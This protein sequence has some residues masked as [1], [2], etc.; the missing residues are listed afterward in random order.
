[1]TCRLCLFALFISICQCVYNQQ[2]QVIHT[3]LDI[4]TDHWILPTFG[5]HDTSDYN[6][7][8]AKHILLQVGREE[9]CLRYLLKKC[10]TATNDIASLIDQGDGHLNMIGGK[11]DMIEKAIVDLNIVNGFAMQVYYYMPFHL[12]ICSHISTFCV[13]AIY[14][15]FPDKKCYEGF[16]SP[17]TVIYQTNKLILNIDYNGCWPVYPYIHYQATKFN[18][19]IQMGKLILPPSSGS[20]TYIDE[21]PLSILLGIGNILEILTLQTEHTSIL[22]IK[23]GCDAGSLASDSACSIHILDREFYIV[24]FHGFHF[25]YGFSTKIIVITTGSKTCDYLS[26]LSLK[27]PQTLH[28]EQLNI[29]TFKNGYSVTRIHNQIQSTWTITNITTSGIGGQ[30]CEYGGLMFFCP[31]CSVFG[32]VSPGPYCWKLKLMFTDIEVTLTRATIIVYGM[33]SYY[34]ISIS[35]RLSPGV[36][37]NNA[38]VSME[39]LLQPKFLVKHNAIELYEILTPPFKNKIVLFIVPSAD[40]KGPARDRAQI[41][42]K[43]PECFVKTTRRYFP[44]DYKTC[45]LLMFQSDCSLTILP[46]CMS[47]EPMVMFVIIPSHSGHIS[48]NN[49]MVMHPLYFHNIYM[50]IGCQVHARFEY[51]THVDGYGLIEIQQLASGLCADITDMLRT[52]QSMFAIS[53]L[54]AKFDDVNKGKL[55]TR[56]PSMILTSTFLTWRAYIR[57]TQSGNTTLQY[58]PMIFTTYDMDWYGLEHMR[59]AMQAYKSVVSP[60]CTQQRCYGVHLFGDVP[61][62]R[63]NKLDDYKFVAGYTVLFHSSLSWNTAHDKCKNEG[64]DLVSLNSHEEVRFFLDILRFSYHYGQYVFIGLTSTMVS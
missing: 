63:D 7:V 44:S 13:Y 30:N 4:I 46:E 8:L 56:D 21:I 15:I 5:V 18:I 20:F 58:T 31:T 10:I 36:K 54:T 38:I 47:F 19:L 49:D 61:I 27:S 59:G 60:V 55:C 33:S 53:L 34:N 16:F 17:F 3:N 57:L 62:F 6:H 29:H 26:Y 37:T 64:H 43:V 32:Y 39:K 11:I 51:Y 48:C 14:G 40:I 50:T 9:Q 52:S 2:W 24:P 41:D 42:F 1:M 12:D 22:K 45:K 35:S 23:H 25:S 28:E